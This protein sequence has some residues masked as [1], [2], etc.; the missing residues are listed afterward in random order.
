MD[1]ISVAKCHEY[2]DTEVQAAVDRAVNALGGL[3][4]IIKPGDRVFLKLNLLMKK[5]PEE[6]VTTHPAVVKAV[7]KKLVK[8]GAHVVIG[9]SP[10]GPFN[11][12]ILNGIYRQC[13]IEEVAK[14]LNVELNYNTEVINVSFPDGE[15]VKQF[16]LCK[17]MVETDKLVSLS[18]LKT[19]GMT[20]FTGAVKVMFGAIPGLEKAEYHFRMPGIKEFSNMLVDLALATKPCFHLV[21]GVVGM[22]GEGPS[23]GKPKDLGVLIAGF[24][25]FAVDAVAVKVAG[26]DPLS[27]PTVVRAKERKLPWSLEHVDLVGDNISFPVAKFEVPEIRREA[28]FPF[29]TGINNFLEQYL[30][31][32]PVF[33]RDIC[34]K[35]GHCV[36][37]CPPKILKMGE[38]N[39]ELDI[40]KCI[41][42][43]CCQELCPEKAVEIKRSLLGKLIFNK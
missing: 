10:G 41:R 20:R 17:A 8:L 26:I 34:S 25:P 19:H 27:V 14:E 31:P 11:K 40:D 5:R 38:N 30:S 1:K 23:G 39:P 43:F 2:S 6:A 3:E 29:P 16:S 33:S 4:S 7:A 24:N 18:K 9:D 21:D 42:C 35:C 13:G 12:T 32:K 37:S 22:E 36:H 15:V 28:R